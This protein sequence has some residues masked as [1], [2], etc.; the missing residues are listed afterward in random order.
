MKIAKIDLSEYA[1]LPNPGLLSY[2][3]RL[4]AGQPDDYRTPYWN[5]APRSAIVAA[6]EEVVKQSNLDSKMPG[7]QE[8]EAKQKEKIGPFSVI[9][10]S[11]KRLD[12]VK[13]FWTMPKVGAPILREAIQREKELFKKGS[14][15]LWSLDRVKTKM[16]LNTNAGLPKFIKRR[17]AWD[18]LLTGNL[19]YPYCAIW[20]TRVQEGGP[21]VEDEKVRDVMMMPMRL[22]M[23]ESQ[24]YYPLLEYEIN[25]NLPYSTGITLRDTELAITKLFDTKGD[26]LVVNTD[27]SKFDQHFN[28]V[29]QSAAHE[30]L[31]YA[32]SRSHH[33]T[34][35][36]TFDVKYNIPLLI[37]ENEVIEGWHGMGSG[38]TGTNPDE[39]LAHHALQQECAI[40]NHAEL[41]PYSRVLGDD[42]VLS[43]KGITVDK[44][45]TSYTRHGLEMNRAKQYADKH[46]TYYLQRYY[47][48]SYRDKYGIMVGVYSTYRALG[49][50]LGQER[51]H[52]PE[53]WGPK[54]VT[55]RALSI[56][57]NCNNHPIFEQFIDFVMKGDKY[58]L[59]LDLPGFYDNLE[60]GWE[61]YKENYDTLSYTQQNETTSINDWK[62]VKYVKS[63]S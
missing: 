8:I 47:H 6:W 37:S 16:R 44:V 17:K 4:K 38:A 40:L 51:F 62:V 53:T 42:G 23:L 45:V 9:P 48:D 5:K 46:S 19:N 7:L 61:G 12:S 27:F 43:F 26:E 28:H 25:N 30:I 14:L 32:F 59:G 56:L 55:Y 60:K 13:S 15:N 1:E 36:A 58:R 31:L 39:N 52:D 10:P 21:S 34:I 11:S 29:M 22:N 54:D 57:E 24:Y 35:N 2:L 20:G 18:E 49:R 3:D 63:K 50:L 41:N 33:S